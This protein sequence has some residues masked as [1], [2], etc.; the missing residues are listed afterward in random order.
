VW[1]A[2]DEAGHTRYHRAHSIY[3]PIVFVTHPPVAVDA[4]TTLWR[5][6]SP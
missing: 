1:P 4:A 2:T 3:P 5:T 6:A